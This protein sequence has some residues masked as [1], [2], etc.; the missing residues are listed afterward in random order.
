MGRELI[1]LAYYVQQVGVLERQS[2][3][4]IFPGGVERIMM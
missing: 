2:K 1:M 4:E 3:L